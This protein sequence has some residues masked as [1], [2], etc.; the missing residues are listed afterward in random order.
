MIYSAATRLGWDVHVWNGANRFETAARFPTAR[1]LGP[2]LDA[3]RARIDTSERAVAI[4]MGHDQRRD[5][6]AL[7]MLVASRATYIG[8]L[9]PRHRTVDIAAPEALAAIRGTTAASLRTRSTIHR[10][11]VR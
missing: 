6:T 7:A 11:H 2:D 9:G 1:V 4:V 3:V 10:A 8:V 5:R